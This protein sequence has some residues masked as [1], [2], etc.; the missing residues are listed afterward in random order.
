MASLFGGGSLWESSAMDLFFTESGVSKLL[1]SSD[2][3][4]TV[5]NLLQ[6]ETI[7]QDTQA[8]TPRLLD[9]CVLC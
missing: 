5:E 2:G 1:D 9:L 8:Q 6:Q 4:L 3:S 7:I